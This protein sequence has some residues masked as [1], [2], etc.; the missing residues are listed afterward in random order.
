[1]KKIIILAV[2]F[3][4]FSANAQS[5]KELIKEV[6][7]LKAQTAEMTA[8][9][10]ALEKKNE[11][12]MEDAQ[13]KLSYA[14]GANIAENLKSQGLDNLDN[15]AFVT[16]MTDAQAGNAK[17]STQ[18]SEQIIQ[19]EFQKLQAEQAKK[20]AAE[21]EVYLAENA[22]KEGVTVLP[23]GLQYEIISAGTGPKP[24]A[25]NEVTVHYTGRLIDGTVFDSS[26]E[27]GQPATFPVTGVIQGW[28]EALQLMP[29]GSK[30]K[31]TIP[32]NLAYGERGTRGIPPFS[33]LVFE[34]ELISIQEPASK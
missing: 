16:G 9:L 23:S 22:K 10:T 27:R 25:S 30:W 26:V 7:K 17:I 6:E 18:E 29:Q 24:T 31:L 13:Q 3:I 32:Y 8:K 4:A 11:V 28:V 1:M 20:A 33:P 21:G 14:L 15:D 5:K 2:A 34:V 12:N 19:A